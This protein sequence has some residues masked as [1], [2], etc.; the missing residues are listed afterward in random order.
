MSRVATIDIGTN[1]TLLLVAE[2]SGGTIAVLEDRAEIT[3]LGRGIGT[4][5]RLGQEGI[6]RTLAV[7]SGYA[8]LAR[9]HEAPIFAIGTEALRRAPN[10]AD[11]LCR[12]AA[13]LDTPVEVI[14]G[15]REAALTFLAARL[16]FPEAASQTMMV[17]DIG[18]G[19]T[20]IVVARRGV[21]ESCRSLPLGSVRLTERHIHH[22]PALADEVAAVRAEVVG[23][24]AEMPFPSEA[25]QPCLVGVAG[26]VTTLAA[27][28]Q[29]LQ[30]YDPGL[31]HGYRL[32]LPALDRQ[33]ERLCASTQKERE[34]MAGLDP[35]RADVILSGAIILCEI[36]RRLGAAQVLVSDRGIRW[37]LLYEKLGSG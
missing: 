17:V 3:R 19:S 1:T 7:L 30:N 15:E 27:M 18:G 29:D 20:E 31:V 14:N 8:V 16:S 10:A 11:F 36:V 22:D 9:V 35:R 26:T 13:L 21:V 34:A 32:T 28:M 5:G 37:G 24:L 12:A 2:A 4:N 33:S 23:H 25:D 6:D